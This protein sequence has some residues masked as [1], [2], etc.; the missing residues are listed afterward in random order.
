MN[1]DEGFHLHPDERF[2]T[3]VGNSMRIPN[4]LLS[5][6]DPKVSTFN[7]QNINYPFFVYGTFP[8]VLNKII[9]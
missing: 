3:M 1:W 7:P 6:L 8:L 5:Y 2:L 9:V 4:N